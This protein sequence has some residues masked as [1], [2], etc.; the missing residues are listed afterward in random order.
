MSIHRET[1]EQKK[2]SKYYF[3]LSVCFSMFQCAC[4]CLITQYSNSEQQGRALSR[5]KN[6]FVLLHKQSFSCNCFKFWKFHTQFTATSGLLPGLSGKQLDA[7]FFFHLLFFLEKN[8]SPQTSGRQGLKQKIMLT[9]C[10]NTLF[11]HPKL[12][13]SKTSA[14]LNYIHP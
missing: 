1:F 4:K 10:F 9:F 7:P 14:I 2:K 12:K 11:T 5:G 8:V 3:Y 13:P 6:S